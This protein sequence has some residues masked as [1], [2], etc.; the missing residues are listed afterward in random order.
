[1]TFF[2]KIKILGWR[3]M[4]KCENFMFCKPGKQ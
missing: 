1:M 3:E 4:K 2:G